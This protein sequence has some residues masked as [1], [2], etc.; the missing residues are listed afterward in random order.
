MSIPEITVTAEVAQQLTATREC[1]ECDGTG[2][3]RLAGAGGPCPL[4]KGAETL[5]VPPWRFHVVV[6]QAPEVPC[7][8]TAF[9]NDWKWTDSETGEPA[10][11]PRCGGSGS[12][13]AKRVQLVV[14]QHRYLYQGGWGRWHT[15]FPWE[16]MDEGEE[17]RRLLLGTATIDERWPVDCLAPTPTGTHAG[18][19]LLALS[20][21]QVRED[22]T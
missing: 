14:E 3:W 20:G 2:E 16:E 12:V 21:Y 5:S 1:P 18:G 19:W 9:H 10:S 22:T 6:D 11:C 17:R 7:P 8:S 13:P 15:C 4:C